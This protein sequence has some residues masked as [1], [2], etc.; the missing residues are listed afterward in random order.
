MKG[1]QTM[2]YNGDYAEDTVQQERNIGANYSDSRRESI[3]CGV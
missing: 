2:Q 3:R 1:V